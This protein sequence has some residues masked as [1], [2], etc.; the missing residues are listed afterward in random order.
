MKIK[1][2]KK[3]LD[4]LDP[5]TE[6]FREEESCYDCNNEYSN[7]VNFTFVFAKGNVE[8]YKE[9]SVIERIHLKRIHGDEKYN[10]IIIE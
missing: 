1:E 2:L 7:T 3:I 5:E 10:S 9:N 8:Y 6:I 4:S